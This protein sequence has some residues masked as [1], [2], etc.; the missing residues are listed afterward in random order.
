MISREI[1]KTL[2]NNPE[3]I[4][5]MGN[6]ER[7]LKKLS[8]RVKARMVKRQP[9]LVTQ[10]EALQDE[11]FIRHIAKRDSIVRELVEQLPTNLQEIIIAEHPTLIARLSPGQITP[12]IARLAIESY[13]RSFESLLRLMGPGMIWRLTPEAALVFAQAGPEALRN[14]A[15][16]YNAQWI[17]D[18]HGEF[19]EHLIAAWE[20]VTGTEWQDLP[21]PQAQVARTMAP[22]KPGEQDLL[23]SK[24]VKKG[25]FL[26]KGYS[27]RGAR[28]QKY[29][30]IPGRLLRGGEPFKLSIASLEPDLVGE[31][32]QLPP[33]MYQLM[34]LHGLGRRADLKR[35]IGWI[36]GTITDDAMWVHEAQSDLMQRTWMFQK[37]DTWQANQNKKIE[38]ARADL[39]RTRQELRT[40]KQQYQSL[41]AAERFRA[42]ERIGELEQEFKQAQIKAKQ[43]PRFHEQHAEYR[44]KIENLH[45]KWIEAFYHVAIWYAK[46]LKKNTLYIATSKDV[47]GAW[48]RQSGDE[49]TI[50]TRAYDG[51]AKKLGAKLITPEP[52]EDDDKKKGMFSGVGGKQWWK[53]DISKFT[54]KE[55]ISRIAALISEDAGLLLEGMDV[56]TLRRALT[57]AGYS[58]INIIKAPDDETTEFQRIDMMAG[59]NDDQGKSY[60]LGD[61][62]FDVTDDRLDHLLN[63]IGH[64]ELRELTP[65]EVEGI[66]ELEEDASLMIVAAKQV[67]G[68]WVGI[69]LVSLDD[70]R[71]QFDIP[72]YRA[73][74]N[75]TDEALMNIMSQQELEDWFSA[76]SWGEDSEAP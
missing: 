50:Y 23:P 32:Q 55:D 6:P 43:R 53:L 9:A 17:V 60:Q 2:L 47:A 61:S 37:G 75:E 66:A 29:G 52:E 59:T 49:T 44:S 24:D 72:T 11:E 7:I 28:G 74:E 25:A 56:D 12:E 45:A 13:E 57:N 27:V 65:D 69:S 19:P 34:D 41:P 33:E 8:A 51:I 70:P 48:G 14:Y 62:Q 54:P 73:D 4:H 46:H 64:G 15:E 3:A 31:V 76:P 58:N 67:E 63:T 38:A 20:N 42:V 16:T 22:D 40:L 18:Q 21:A 5:S 71:F 68:R 35:F 30:K 26:K 1:V 10:Y 36:G 39:I